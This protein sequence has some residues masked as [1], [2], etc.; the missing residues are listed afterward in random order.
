MTKSEKFIVSGIV[1]GVGFRYFTV[2]EGIKLGLTGYARNKSNGNVEVVATGDPEQLDSLYEW[3]K[4][5][6]PHASVENI[7]RTDYFPEKPFK[8]FS[9]MY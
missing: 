8:R 9:I 7:E 4:V 1:Q 3:L 2:N 6:S 5:G